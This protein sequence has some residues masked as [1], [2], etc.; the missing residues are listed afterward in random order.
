MQVRDL[1]PLSVRGDDKA[2]P[3][4]TTDEGIGERRVLD[5]A[6]SAVNGCAASRMHDDAGWPACATRSLQARRSLTLSGASRE[7]ACNP[8]CM[9]DGFL[10][11]DRACTLCRPCMQEAVCYIAHLSR[12]LVP[13]SSLPCRRIVVED[14]R[15]RQP[16]DERD[17]EPLWLRRMVFVA[18]RALTQSEAYLLPASALE[19]GATA[20]S[21]GTHVS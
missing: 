20:A 12:L 10:A 9:Q 16:E 3:I 5:D 1:T 7:N 13:M 11:A 15:M 17:S 6:H 4:L 21:N 19:Q 14:V 8:S 2:V 18:N